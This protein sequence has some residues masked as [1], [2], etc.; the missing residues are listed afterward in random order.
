MA[1]AMQAKLEE[2]DTGHRAMKPDFKTLLTCFARTYLI[3]AAFNTKG[4]QN[5]GL[6]YAMDP[7][8]RALYTET[9]ELR[10]ARKRYLKLYNTHPYWTPMLVGYFLFLE[11]RMAKGLAPANALDD[12]RATATYTL[13]AIGDSFFGGSILVTWSL[14]GILLLLA[15]FSSV[16]LAW[17]A[18]AFILLQAF[19][20]VTFWLGWRRG[21]TVMQQLKRLNLIGWAERI[22]VANAMFI[23]WLWY[24]IYP[25]SHGLLTFG[26]TTFILGLVSLGVFKRLFP[27]EIIVVALSL[28]WF[29]G[30]SLMENG[31]AF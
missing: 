15:G 3:G 6:A 12:I 23:L 28:A 26:L 19:R 31:S 29:A 21:L 16:A 22:K 30:R 7:G 13:S 8:L 5:I 17:L 10:Q 2:D 20:F 25:L 14:V 27:R 24:L 4:L 9:D 1:S 18:G 11:S